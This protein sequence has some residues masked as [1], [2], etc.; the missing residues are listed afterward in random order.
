MC[1]AS[2]GPR[3]IR[4]ACN[5]ALALFVG[6]LALGRGAAAQ[7]QDEALVGQLAGLLQAADAR[8]LDAP[9]FRDALQS[10]E[11][12]VRR[13]AALAAGQIGAAAAFAL[14][15][16]KDPR[17]I[18][19]LLA[20]V[21]S[22]PADQQGLP[23]SEAVT[24][25]AKIGGDAAAQALQQLLGNGTTAGVPTSF[26][27]STALLESWRLGARAPVTALIG[28][29]E[30]PDLGARWHAL[31]SL[32]RLHVARAVDLLLTATQDR[33]PYV[34]SIAARGVTRAMVDSAH[35]DPRAALGRIRPLLAD[36]DARV[37]I[38]ALRA[39]ATFHDSTIASLVAPLATDADVN[40]AVQAETTL[41]VTGGA[42]AGEILQ[43]RLTTAVFAIRRQALVALAQ[44]DSAR[45]AAAAVPLAGDADWR[46]RSVAAEAFGAARD[47]AGLEA[48]LTD[49]DGRVVAQALQALARIVPDQDTS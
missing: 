43:G 29:A 21:R 32:G 48:E 17:A 24:A 16:L 14:G 28:Y 30:D 34:R 4:C 9:R 41:G 31:Y 25:I 3:P 49:A 37:R 13:Q 45:G 1:A 46:W 47:R 7:Q 12:A 15:L 36:Q 33:D 39:L 22:V 44:A 8:V 38:N 6:G 19:P 5:A 11:P 27:A 35:L 42:V 40:V 23:Q 18:S 2:S 26:A 20:K 10:P